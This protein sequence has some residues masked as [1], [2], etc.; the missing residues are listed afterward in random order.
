M[1]VFELQ[2]NLIK[3][4]A[5]YVKS[6]ISIRDPRIDE[7]VSQDLD[8]GLLWPEA[9]LGLNPS[10][11]EGG[12]IDEL[13]AE[14]LLHPGCSEIFRVKPKDAPSRG[15]RLHRHQREAIEAARAG[16]NYV[17]TTGTGS[18]KSLS[19][20]I[21]I[22]DHVLRSERKPGIKAIVV[23]PMNALANSQS[24]ELEKF[25]ALPD[26]RRPVTFK[27]YTGQER[28]E[29]KR[30]ILLDP[31][32]ILL[33]NYVMLELV[34][35]RTA[36][37]ALVGAA[38]GLRF[39]VL[40]EL[41]TYRGRQGADVALLVRRTRDACAADNLQC[42]GT[43]ATMASAGGLDEQRA[44]VAQVASL[45][46]GT[47]VEPAH[48]IGETLKR[49]TP[50]ADGSDA[51]LEALTER[52][53]DLEAPT[54]ASHEAFVA[55]PLSSWI[56]SAFGTVR[57]ADTGRLVRVPP[58][59]IRGTDG[60]AQQLADQ[61][62][63]P[64]DVCITAIQ[65]Q[66]LAGVRIEDPQTRMPVFAFRLHQ[67]ISRGDAAYASLEAEDVRHITVHP[68][69]YVPGDRDRRLF[70]LVFCRECGQEYYSVSLG[71]SEA[72]QQVV[73]RPPGD[74]ADG[75][76]RAGYIRLSLASPWPADALQQGRYPEDWLEPDG[77]R[78]TGNARKLVPRRIEVHPDGRVAPGGTVAHFLTTPFRLCLN[79]GVSYRGHMRSDFAKLGT[80]GSEGRSTAT[81]ILS[82]STVRHLRADELLDKEAR[83]LLSFTDNRQDASLQAGHFNDFVQVGLLRSG[84][85]RA[86]AAAG[87]A[88]LA[89]DDLTHKVTSAL[90]L[91][92]DELRRFWAQN[93]DAVFLLAEEALK[94]LRQVTGYRLY[95]DQRRGWRIT[96]PNLEQTG[97]LRIEYASLPE[98]CAYEKVWASRHLALSTASPATREA[99]CR[100]L[101]DLMRRELAIKVDYLRA[102][103]QERLVQASSQYLLEPWAIDEKEA[104]KLEV[105]TILLPRSQREGD[106][107]GF[108]FLSARGGFGQY[109]RRQSTFPL[110]Q[111]MDTAT[112]AQVIRDL[113]AALAETGLVQQ[114]Q[115]P[116]PGVEGSVPGYQLLAAAMRW[117]VGDGTSAAIDPIRVPRPPAEGSR[118]NRFFLEFYKTAAAE[119]HGIEAREHTAQ[120][121]YSQRQDREDR[122]RSADLPV[123]F[124]SPT[125][126]L[127]VDI[128]QLNV[129]SLR[130]VPPTPANY[131]QRSGRAG[132]SGQPAL[133]FTY[134]SSGSPHDQYFFRRPQLMVSGQVAPPR[135]DLVNED[136]IRAHVHA[137]WLAESG[138]SLQSSLA[139]LLDL[140]GSPRP[141]LQLKASV[142][143]DI[144]SP[145]P[146]QQAL[147]RSK[148]V[149]A[150]LSDDLLAARWWSD[151]W[152]ADVIQQTALE[153]EAACERWRSLYRAAHSQAEAQQ[154]VILDHTRNE[155]DRREARRLRAEAEAQLGLLRAEGSSSSQSDFYSYRYFAS[156]GFLPG[157][158]FPR[159]P[160]SAFIPGRRGARGENEFLS[161]PRF[162]AI[163]EFGPRNFIYHEGSRY[164]I[165]RVILPVADWSESGTERAPI[166]STAKRCGSCG[167]LH[168][169]ASGLGADRCESCDALLGAALTQ[170]F[171]LQNVVTK[172]RDRINSDE[173]ERQRMGYQIQSAV[174]FAE[175]AGEPIKQVATA[176]KDGQPLLKLTYGHAAT[177]RRIN[178]GW[179]RRNASTP[180]GFF[181]DMERGYWSKAGG[182]D[183]EEGEDD[184]LTPRKERVVPYVDDRRN[185][186]L[187]EPQRGLSPAFMASLQA[188]LKS[189]IQ[190][191]FQLEDSELA[192]EPLPDVENRRYLLLYEA[193]EGGAGVLRRLVD[194][195][196][197]LPQ[198]ARAALEICHFDPD[199]GEDRGAAPG[200][201]ER[202][203]A[204]CYDCLMSYTNQPD[205]PLLDRKLLVESLLELASGSVA[206]AP[207]AETRAQHV[208]RLGKLAGSQLERRWLELVMAGNHRLPSDAQRLI[209]GTR[210]DFLYDIPGC[211]AA[212]YI[213]GPVHD[214]AD[215]QQLDETKEEA[216]LDAGWIVI[217][218][219]HAA[220]WAAI[221]KK[222]PSVFGTG[223]AA[224]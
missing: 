136:L 187:L 62:G 98:I 208:E 128:A 182:P 196:E 5:S 185:A 170:L 110:M 160:L 109:L 156:E 105:A 122:F 2:R 184:P 90:G 56:E 9:R 44:A 96:S 135:L 194:D 34:L 212:I 175:V 209:L 13:V 59:P 157:Y 140:G 131:A 224:K 223:E 32:D 81:T 145:A 104:E 144:E 94:A 141:T 192:A 138:L 24:Q 43:S 80:L 18:G 23:Y 25:L 82:L 161:R 163:S 41:H 152:L 61:T 188:A 162:L 102:D 113:L 108:Y 195:P 74:Q 189:A 176:T 86:V 97:L 4:Y 54:P 70:P 155:G 11:A 101:L 130:N 202:C 27:R 84:L 119:G 168:P 129:V 21:P 139:D 92:K 78:L 28:E 67:F 14:G 73:A 10:F 89:H 190:V 133:V 219:H 167:Y 20:I 1:N 174:R 215:R 169:V 95:L 118:P 48:V 158:S 111:G 88:G 222:W 147:A 75:D 178:L 45:I 148:R 173:E 149:L 172:R 35:T 120:V 159:L 49:A 124:C 191:F 42:V 31:P 116:K 181:L 207:G 47:K 125:M 64:E 37:R 100:T 206:C 77:M 142:K 40:D 165:N 6:F 146:R 93:P 15:L 216:L 68:Q 177:V 76:A 50:E 203:E 55:D 51:F 218:F 19:Y 46:F 53:G 132:R 117:V 151:R 214:F 179:K 79:C 112:V 217:R 36:E 221:L 99:V 204:G 12:W 205:H 87:A 57:D 121:P 166:T 71:G 33:T 180:P 183:A 126:E 91:D 115:E 66:L 60:A 107:R 63:L 153:F 22:V 193:A 16:F 164:L 30:A 134:C 186:L 201:R 200:A 199:T 137:V 65:E 106:Y 83:K 150:G 26:G 213:D 171:R 220:D 38:Q 52:V 143:A 123:L 198:V 29:E 72:D 3:D 7:R 103:F 17:L 69:Q 8:A 154:A 39:L 210:P 197:A 85:Y 58:C 127:G 114:V 211:R